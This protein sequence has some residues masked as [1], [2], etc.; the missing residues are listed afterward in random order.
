MISAHRNLRLLGSSN[1][2]ASASQVAGIIGTHH[3]AQLIF[4]YLGRDW[5]SPCWAG[6]S[7][8][9]DLV[10]HL[11]WLP[12]VLGLQ[13]GAAAPGPCVYFKS[14]CKPILFMYHS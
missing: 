8:S 6:W 4:V 10:I 5:V 3:H 14:S 13:A 2:P 9:L 12:K 1:S 11:P 7:Q